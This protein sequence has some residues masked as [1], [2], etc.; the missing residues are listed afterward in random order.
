MNQGSISRRIRGTNWLYSLKQV[1][2]G[3]KELSAQISKPIHSESLSLVPRGQEWKI[4]SSQGSNRES[5][6]LRNKVK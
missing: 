6:V 2:P 4:G 5:T 3:L 1:F